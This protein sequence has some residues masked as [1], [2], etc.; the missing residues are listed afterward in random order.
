MLFNN[1][2]LG[3][4]TNDQESTIIGNNNTVE[5]DMDIDINVGNN[6]GDEMGG[7]NFS[8]GTTQSPIIE[9][10]QERVVNRTIVHNV[11]HVCPIRTRI[12]NHHIFRHTYCPRYSCCEQNVCSNVQC[13]SCNQCSRF[14]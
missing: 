10:M 12:I 9:P 5:Q 4:I 13:G 14:R 2:T 11:P 6:V 3:D 1:P 8:L 7:N